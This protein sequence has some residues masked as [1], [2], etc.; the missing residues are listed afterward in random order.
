MIVTEKHTSALYQAIFTHTIA[1]TS[2]DARH[3]C[4]VRE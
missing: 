4:T 1:S 3:R 2:H